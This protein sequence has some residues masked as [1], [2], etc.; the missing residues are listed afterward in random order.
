MK[1]HIIIIS[2]FFITTYSNVLFSQDSEPSKSTG[3][4][5]NTSAE[6]ILES[7]TGKITTD[8][9]S[10][11]ESSISFDSIT[12]RV[13]F[14]EKIFWGVSFEKKYYFEENKLNNVE[15]GD[16]FDIGMDN[17]LKGILQDYR[18]YYTRM[19][20]I[21]TEKY[22][23]PSNQEGYNLLLNG[24]NELFFKKI[25]D[26]DMTIS[27]EWLLD[28]ERISFC[29]QYFGTGLFAWYISYSPKFYLIAMENKSIKLKEAEKKAR[30][31]KRR[32][33]SSYYMQSL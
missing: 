29:F 11:V 13:I 19:L 21:L 15:I 4:E 9:T 30:E 23:Y 10:Y 22:G 7:E 26:E 28:D 2:I 14:F 6:K 20:N 5:W 12:R 25:E 3:I 1:N 32:K 17:S 16:F 33:E 31:A 27:S 18:V 24:G 8:K